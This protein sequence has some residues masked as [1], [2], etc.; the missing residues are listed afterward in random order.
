M[1]LSGFSAQPVLSP[2]PPGPAPSTASRPGR[3]AGPSCPNPCREGT[4]RPGRLPH[5]TAACRPGKT[6]AVHL[7]HRDLGLG[8]R[9]Q[10]I[11]SSQSHAREGLFSLFLGTRNLG[12]REVKARA[13]GHTAVS[14]GPERLTNVG[15]R[16][17]W[18]CPQT[19]QWGR[20]NHRSRGRNGRDPAPASASPEI[21]AHPGRWEAKG[22]LPCP[23][24]S[25]SDG[26]ARCWKQS[27]TCL[28]TA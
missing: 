15:D 14:R 19:Q 23:R 22:R 7:L 18:C 26:L 25:H 9:D 27:A 13:H 21:L 6:G 20:V 16:W 24:R 2:S 1:Q 17:G 5:R 11:Q 4:G 8:P 28:R 10:R 12:H 3:R